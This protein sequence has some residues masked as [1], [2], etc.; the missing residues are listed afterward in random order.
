MKIAI[1]GHTAG[2]GKAFAEQLS[3][4]GHTIVGISRREGEN[5]RRIPHT[6]SLIEPCDLFINNAQAVYA[7]TEL[8]YEVWSRWQSDKRTDKHIWNIST[9]MTE[10]PINSN[11]DGQDDITMS[12]YRNQKLALEEASRQL[13]FK[14]PWPR[15]SVIRPGGVATQK[16]FD[17]A[18]KADANWWVKTVIDTFSQNDNINITEISISFTNK[19]IPL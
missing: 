10:Q 18:G 5:I 6:A 17:N 8:L 1:T 19:R 16:N 13:R 3:Q 15:I 11:P 9:M 2:I 14:K 7:Q 12:Q 4:R